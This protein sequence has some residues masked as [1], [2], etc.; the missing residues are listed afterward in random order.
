M[1]KG[2]YGVGEFGGGKKKGDVGEGGRE[3]DGFWG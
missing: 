2:Y 1:G 3:Y